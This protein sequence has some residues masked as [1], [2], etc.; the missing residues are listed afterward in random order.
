[1]NVRYK[2]RLLFSAAFSCLLLTC[3]AQGVNRS[4]LAQILNFE[5]EQTGSMPRGWGGGPPETIFLDD[6]IVHSGKWAVRLQRDA[7]SSS[8]N[9]GIVTSAGQYQRAHTGR[10]PLCAADRTAGVCGVGTFQSPEQREGSLS[11]QYF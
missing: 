8:T 3:Q 5:V 6:K 1:M 7:S 11:S 2:M 9:S 4:E 10:L